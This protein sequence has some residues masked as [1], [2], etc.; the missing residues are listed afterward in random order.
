M[1]ALLEM[2]ERGLVP[3]PLMRMGARHLIAARLRD[4]HQ[5]DVESAA[6]RYG[7][8]LDELRASPLAL[9]TAAANQQHYEVSDQFF[10][11]AL[12]PRLK[13]SAC[14]WPPGVRN[15]ADAETAM[16][17]LY[18]ERAGLEDGMRILDLG[19]G[20]GSLTLWLAARHPNSMIL[21]VSNSASQKSVIDARCR[22]LGL[23]NVRV[24]TADV[25]HF[26]LDERF[27][28]V[29]SI[30]MFEHMRNYSTLLNR[31]ASWL[32]PHG[33]LFVHIFCHRYLMYPFE[34]SGP[35]DWM[36]RHFF[37]GGLMPA[38][39]TLLHFQDQL[40]IDRRW[41]LSGT[42]YQRTARAWLDNLDAN[43]EAASL[44]LG[45]EGDR[46]TALRDVQRW[47]MFFIACEELFGWRRGNEWLVAH[48][49]FRRR[50]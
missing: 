48:Y 50:D 35:G 43:I 39:D 10:R 13:Y 31:I 12:G 18:A 46:A 23:A 37:T 44:A 7:K 47:R 20:W 27:D 33:K 41:E 36:G 45:G 25:N 14:Y 24:R 2:A 15:L 29:V 26:Q 22:A 19:C 4:E 3:D 8:L 40:Q 42:H 28:R 30:E 32:A 21:A 11:L 38:T 5:G 9:E 1:K 34:T 6:R 49:L 16:L 17:E